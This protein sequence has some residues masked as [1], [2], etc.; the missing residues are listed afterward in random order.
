MIPQ[1]CE[2]GDAACCAKHRRSCERLELRNAIISNSIV[3]K[4]N[5]WIALQL[6]PGLGMFPD[7]FPS[8]SQ[9]LGML[10]N[11]IAWDKEVSAEA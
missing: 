6:K 2:E 9:E 10:Q 11:H 5:K 8:R 4:L 7:T 3:S 1:Y